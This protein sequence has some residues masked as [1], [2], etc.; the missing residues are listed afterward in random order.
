MK[1]SR[2]FVNDYTKIDDVDTN[3]LTQEMVRIG[4]ESES[5]KTLVSATKLVIGHVIECI[6][7][8]ESDHLNLC[9]VD[10]KSEVLNIVCGAPNVRKDIKVIVALDGCILPKG[11][12]KKSMILGHESNGMLC[13]LDEL[14]IEQKYLKKE[15][16]DGISELPSDAPIGEDPIKYLELDDEIIDFELTSNRADLL[17]ELGLA[18][19]VSAITDREVKEPKIKYNEID[20][21][22]KDELNLKID[23]DNVFTF[24]TKKVI[25]IEIKESPNFI[26]NRLI[27]CGIRPINN[28]VDISNYIML[29]TGQPLHFYD[30]DRLGNTISARMAH[31]GEKVTTLDNNERL[32]SSNDIVITNGKDAIGLAGVM[33]G[34]STEIEST[35]KNVVIESAIF[36]PINIRNTSKKILRSEASSRYEKGLDVNRCYYAIERACTLL[37]E[38]AGGE[39]CKGMLEYNTLDRNNK[40]IEIS[41]DKINSVLGYKL[42][43]EDV[44]DVFRKL[45]FEVTEKNNIF[46]VS[47][48]TRRTDI[49]IVEDLI[50]EVGRIYGVDNIESTLPKFETLP[51]NY[52]KRPR[53]IRNIM[54]SLGLNEVIT[55]SLI[56]EK[57]VFKFTNDEFG[58]IQVSSPLSE[59]K[60]TLRHSLISSLLSVY[61]YNK[62]RNIKDLSIFEISKGF[63]KINTEVVE[64]NLLSALVTGRYS[65]GLEVYNYDFYTMKGIVEEILERLGYKNRYTFEVR[66]FPCEM[67]PYQSAYININGTIVGYFGKVH[68]SLYKEDIYV[69]EINLNTLFGI[70]SGK[71][72]Y[73]E[74]TKYPSITKDLSFIINKD[75]L[76]DDIITTIRKN[77][78]GSLKSVNAVDYYEDE[79][80]GDNKK[81]ITFKLT[82]E[83]FDKTLT[84][85][86][87]NPLIDNVISAVIK[88]HNGILR[89]K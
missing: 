5:T 11:T 80:L 74:F 18:Y 37:S 39:V 49:S 72:K 2:K 73:R 41:L 26:K 33:G 67:N 38:Y 79:S 8:P 42:S 83:S 7:H 1:L 40:E 13:A 17:S 50:E 4:N 87:I 78:K 3:Y 68:P 84:D 45:K 86:E 85:E 51:G 69:M 82:F 55:Y 71:I 58:L 15:D 36:R 19:E 52:D 70:K 22:I 56:N 89:D 6:P 76:C 60:T 9:K 21:N 61:D 23:T 14:G 75:V 44:L 31:D 46:K 35:T 43:I 47:V 63:S 59:D 77:G 16:I 12:I 81:A 48:P 64:E 30:A 20:K 34:L 62:A 29:E 10:I 53:L 57:D 65:E 28:V 32:L 27:A 24:L 54:S 25:N 66:E 88:N